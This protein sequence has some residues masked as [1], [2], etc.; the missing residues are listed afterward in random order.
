MA[1]VLGQW[2]WLLPLLPMYGCGVSQSDLDND[3]AL[4][5]LMLTVAEYA[6]SCSHHVR[7][8]CAADGGGCNS[9]LSLERAAEQVWSDVRNWSAMSLNE[10][11]PAPVYLS[12]EDDPW[13]GQ[14][15][16]WVMNPIDGRR[17][18]TA[19]ND[20]VGVSF[21]LMRASHPILGAVSGVFSDRRFMAAEQLGARSQEWGQEPERNFVSAVESLSASTISSGLPAA[22][23]L[24]AIRPVPHL[25]PRTHV[26]RMTDC[27]SLDLWMLRAAQLRATSRPGHALR[28]SRLA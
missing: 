4:R 27:S 3:K 12:S 6:V 5:Q 1:V 15:Y 22:G 13:R 8:T 20:R 19:G 14:D 21:A 23:G 7:R 26:L 24:G 25:R 16:A 28:M 11:Y 2:M 9:G 17:N 10:M 18:P